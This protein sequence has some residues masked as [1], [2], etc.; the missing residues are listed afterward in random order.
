MIILP[1]SQ[2][3]ENKRLTGKESIEELKEFLCLWIGKVADMVTMDSFHGYYMEEM[4]EQ[5]MRVFLCNH[6]VLTFHEMVAYLKTHYP[7]YWKAEKEAF[8]YLF[9]VQL[10]LA[11]EYYQIKYPQKSKVF[12]NAE[13]RNI[14]AEKNEIPLP[15]FS[16]INRLG[17]KFNPLDPAKILADTANILPDPMELDYTPQMKL[18][19]NALILEAK[20]WNDAFKL[21]LKN[22][23]TAE[24]EKAG[25]APLKDYQ[26][27]MKFKQGT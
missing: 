21:L 6:M 10:E 14:I 19:I 5:E 4:N 8:I 18:F 16:M 23:F 1:L 25:E 27:S 24:L 2:P 9:K 3:I 17:V 26:L 7:A 13:L 15:Q 20:N 22:I 12:L 11:F